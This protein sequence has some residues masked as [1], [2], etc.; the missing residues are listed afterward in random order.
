MFRGFKWLL[1]RRSGAGFSRGIRTFPPPNARCRELERKAIEEGITLDEAW[2]RMFAGG[3]SASGG[4]K[5]KD[6]L[7]SAGIELRG[8][9]IKEF[10]IA[11]VQ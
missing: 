3:E 7:P 2:K 6:R 1:A 5:K 4:R 9:N 11:S 10:S 8:G